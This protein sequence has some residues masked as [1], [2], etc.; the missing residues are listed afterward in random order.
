[1]AGHR[2]S[3]AGS[4]VLT[5]FEESRATLASVTG[6][7]EEEIAKVKA[8]QA[9]ILAELDQQDKQIEEMRERAAKH[10]KTYEFLRGKHARTSA[11]VRHL[12]HKHKSSEELPEDFLNENELYLVGATQN[13]YSYS[14]RELIE[15]ESR[16]AAARAV[17]YLLLLTGFQLF[18]AY[19]FFDSCVLLLER[20]YTPGY[21]PGPQD[22]SI[23][24]A[25]SMLVDRDAGYDENGWILGGQPRIHLMC[26][27]VSAFILGI[28]LKQDTMGTLLSIHPIEV[29]L[30]EI[31]DGASSKVRLFRRLIALPLQLVWCARAAVI[32]VM[33]ALGSAYSFATSNS[34]Q[35]IVLNSC[36]IGFVFDLD[37]IFYERL[38]PK[39]VKRDYESKPAIPG[40]PLDVP[41]S[42]GLVESVSFIVYIIDV[43]GMCIV[44]ATVRPRSEVRGG[45]TDLECTVWDDTCMTQPIDTH[46]IQNQAMMAILLRATVM[47]LG[48][49]ALITNERIQEPPTSHGCMHY[50][51]MAFTIVPVTVQ[52]GL[53]VLSAMA[54][55]GLYLAYRFGFSYS[56]VF[57]YMHFWFPYGRPVPDEP[58]MLGCFYGRFGDGMPFDDIDCQLFHTRQGVYEALRGEGEY[59]PTTLKM[60][61]I[62]DTYG[63]LQKA[64]VGTFGAFLA[65]QFD[66]FDPG[67][68]VARGRDV[69]LF[70]FPN[71]AN[72]GVG[73]DA[74]GDLG[75]GSGIE[76]APPN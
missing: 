57:N 70:A 5:L 60:E 36:A 59:A 7:S 35:D 21:R 61:T 20:L 28:Y 65:A 52:L 68:F 51:K 30:H 63:D 40:S 56:Y 33:A 26:S 69:L 18:L 67:D 37:D 47:S 32:P 66:V 49:L 75:S 4:R 55:V 22:N 39:A 23:F 58:T 17:S 74:N 6:P 34:V 3:I 45:M 48:H 44:F 27:I 71:G 72:K 38:M 46:Q 73:E 42:P 50:L 11:A 10:A 12:H 15:P 9:L 24:Y 13:I 14:M 2:P 8:Q 29:L 31:P 41:G 54:G 19:G 53:S 64:W 25:S 43:L 16:T 1:M 76:G 62:L